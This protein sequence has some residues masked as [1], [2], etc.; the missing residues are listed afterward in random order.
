MQTQVQQLVV[1][2]EEPRSRVRCCRLRRGLR[3]LRTGRA[4]QGSRDFPQPPTGPEEDGHPSNDAVVLDILRPATPRGLANPLLTSLPS[5]AASPAASA[6]PSPTAAFSSSSPPPNACAI[7]GVPAG[8]PVAVPAEVQEGGGGGAAG[9]QAGVQAA[10]SSSRGASPAGSSVL[11]TSPPQLV[12]LPPSDATRLPVVLS[13]ASPAAIARAARGGARPAASLPHLVQPQGEQAGVEDLADIDVD[14]VEAPS[15][16][17]AQAG[18]GTQNLPT[19]AFAT[20]KS[21]SRGVASP[22]AS[23]TPAWLRA[24]SSVRGY[25]QHGDDTGGYEHDG[26]QLARF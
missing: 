12:A 6:A 9:V 3:R 21:P 18:V 23:T 22:A 2:E 13:P 20:A 11:G 24:A 14:I 10:A 4:G 1:V 15:A 5:A 26:V 7:E 25:E 17:H 8:V 19:P 16:L